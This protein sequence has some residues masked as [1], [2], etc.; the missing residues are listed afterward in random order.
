MNHPIAK[1]VADNELR[2]QA[3]EYN[4][5]FFAALSRQRP[6][7]F[8]TRWSLQGEIQEGLRLFDVL[9]TIGK[10]LSSYQPA[11]EGEGQ[12]EALQR[13]AADA[14]FTVRALSTARV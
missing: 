8:A 3:A 12:Y 11:R 6:N 13:Q 14:V 4:Q 1:D 5:A 2:R 9:G 10:K 7:R